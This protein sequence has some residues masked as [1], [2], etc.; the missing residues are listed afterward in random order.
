MA[1]LP[2]AANIKGKQAGLPTGDGRSPAD[3]GER[4]TGWDDHRDSPPALGGLIPG[5]ARISRP[6][7]GT[8]TR[9]VRFRRNRRFSSSFGI[10]FGN[11]HK[12][13]IKE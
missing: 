6:I 8:I 13:M 5:L 10:I 9:T 4:L 7:T 11:I 2:G 1:V 12:T 3:E